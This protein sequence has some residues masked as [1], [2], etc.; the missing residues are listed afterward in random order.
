MHGYNIII[1]IVLDESLTYE[2][3]GI[4]QIFKQLTK[5]A[6]IQK[7]V[8][9]LQLYKKVVTLRINR[10]SNSCALESEQLENAKL[11]HFGLK[12]LFD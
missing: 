3:A 8:V 5:R 10:F 6:I 12:S 7:K 11:V 9:T 2:S 4:I 1:Q